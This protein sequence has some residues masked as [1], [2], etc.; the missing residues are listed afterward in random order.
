MHEDLREVKFVSY[1]YLFQA[2]HTLDMLLNN[3]TSPQQAL[4][5]FSFDC[6]EHFKPV[7]DILATLM[8]WKG[9][10]CEVSILVSCVERIKTFFE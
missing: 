6:L 1:N 8:T 4:H 5:A 7:V 10:L 2:F 9:A 3:L